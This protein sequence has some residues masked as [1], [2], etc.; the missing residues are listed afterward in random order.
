MRIAATLSSRLY[1]LESPNPKFRVVSEG[2]E[3]RSTEV[4]RGR[5]S[6]R[7]ISR[8]PAA[9]RSS[10]SHDNADVWIF[11]KEG[12]NVDDVFTCVQTQTAT[13]GK[14]TQPWN[15]KHQENEN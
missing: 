7:S 10:G 13:R 6:I 1:G 9:C 4:D 15:T 5:D 14:R 12:P 11:W 3:S 2:F 8:R